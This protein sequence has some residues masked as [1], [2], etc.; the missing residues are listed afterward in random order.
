IHA[1][2]PA[3]IQ[4]T[5]HCIRM[6]GARRPAPSKELLN[7]DPIE[8]DAASIGIMKFHVSP[9]ASVRGD[10]DPIWPKHRGRT[11]DD[12]ALSGHARPTNRAVLTLLRRAAGGRSAQAR[13]RIGRIGA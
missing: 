1:R 9:A 6:E 2:W 5:H 3:Q 8:P 12:V 10:G 13:L 7:M 11:L 4:S